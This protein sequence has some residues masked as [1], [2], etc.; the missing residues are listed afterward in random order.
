MT[1]KRSRFIYVLTLVIIGVLVYFYPNKY[2]A[3]LFYLILILPFFSFATILYVLARFKLSHELDANKIVK[4]DTVIYTCSIHNE[5]IVPYPEIKVIFEGEHLIFQNQFTSPSFVLMPKTQFDIDLSLFCKYRGLY[6]VGLKYIEITDF[7]NLFKIR[8]K[9]FAHKKILVY[10]KVHYFKNFYISR[11]GNL[12]S[13][14]KDKRK[15]LTNQSLAE[16][17]NHEYGERLSLIHWKLS[18]RMGKL[19]S[20]RMESITDE[21]YFIFIDLFKS[22]LGI[23]ENIVL[24]DKLIE[25]FV[26]FINVILANNLPFELKYMQIDGLKD[27]KYTNYSQFEYFYERA[28]LM[29]FSKS[30]PLHDLIDQSNLLLS[31][32]SL[33]QGKLFIFTF[34]LTLLLLEDLESRII[35]G[36]E[37]FLFYVSPKNLVNDDASAQIEAENIRRAVTLGIKVY[38]ADISDDISNLLE[39]EII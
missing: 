4:G 11:I 24:E 20:K 5:D 31:E 33:T 6:N 22:D 30:K 28:A 15:I 36:F 34:S 3:M 38:Q 29:Q 19:M 16:I 23:E 1:M 32:S 27:E 21:Q 35:Q 10:P 26:S 13:G 8:F 14:I 37:V 7:F 12:E 2:F 17:K 25:L 9:N 18:A 39:G